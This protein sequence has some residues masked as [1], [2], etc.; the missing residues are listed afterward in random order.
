VTYKKTNKPSIRRYRNKPGQPDLAI[1]VASNTSARPRNAHSPVPFIST[2]AGSGPNWSH[3]SAHS[4]HAS[5]LRHSNAMKVDRSHGGASWP[6]LKACRN[7]SSRPAQLRRLPSVVTPQ[8]HTRI[9]ICH[10][11][12]VAIKR[13]CPHPIRPEYR[14]RQ[15]SLK[16]L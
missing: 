10:L 6:A 5:G 15:L 7:N 3:I 13:Q 2:F 8:I 14:R 11:I 4:S 16:T 12:C 1:G 9:Q